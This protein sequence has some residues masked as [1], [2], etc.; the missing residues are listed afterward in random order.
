MIIIIIIIDY[1][2]K[3]KD[4]KILNDRAGQQAYY[5]EINFDE[6]NLDYYIEICEKNMNKYLNDS[7]FKKMYSKLKLKKFYP[8]IS[9][10]AFVEKW[11]MLNNQKEYRS[12]SFINYFKGQW[13][14]FKSMFIGNDDFNE[15][16]EDKK[17]N[18]KNIINESNNDNKKIEENKNE[19]N[20]DT[21]KK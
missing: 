6:I 8:I 11:V 15:K 21:K 13:G 7:K 2:Y 5:R 16:K 17:E 1:Y 20:I 10:Q 9:E 19:I 18:E 12:S 4:K 3:L 14:I